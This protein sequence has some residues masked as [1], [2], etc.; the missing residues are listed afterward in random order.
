MTEEKFNKA[1]ELKKEISN[2]KQMLPIY[3]NRVKRFDDYISFMDGRKNP[4]KFCGKIYKKAEVKFVM[5]NPTM[6][7]PNDL[8]D[9]VEE[10]KKEF[11]DFLS[12]CQKN[13]KKKLET[14]NS[15]IEKLNKEFEEL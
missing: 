1:E 2:R 7:D 15:D 11:V 8:F 14:L 4:V 13:Y 6:T 5:D 3:I 10:N 9:M 12:K